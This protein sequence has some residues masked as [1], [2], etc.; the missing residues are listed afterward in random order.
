MRTFTLQQS[1]TEV[2]TPHGGLALVG[3]CLNRHTSL[4]QT[5]RTVVKRHGIPNIDLIR[6]Y[7]GLITLGKSDF[8]AVESARTDPFFKDAMGIKQ[9]PSSAQLRQRFDEDAQALT[10]LLED[11]S[12][13]FLKSVEAPV[14]PLKMGHVALDMDVFPMD[15]SQTSKE[16]VS[17]TYKGHDGYA[18]IAAYLGQEGWC[19][20]C[21]LRPGNQHANNGFL[22]TLK[23]VLPR[24]RSLTGSPILLRLDSAHDA[25][26]NRDFLSQQEQVD[27]LIKW[28]PRKQDPL[29]WADKAQEQ[30]GWALGRY[31]KMEAVLSE[32]LPDEPGIR[33]I[34]KVTVRTSDAQGQLYL[35]PDVR[36]EGW[37]TSL[38]VSVA[39]NQQVIDLYC[40]HATSEQFHSEFKTDLD[41]ERLPSGKF[42][43][44]NLVMTFATLGYNV[45]RWMGLRLTGP[46]APVRH[47]AKRRRLRTVMQELMYM[48]CR[49][50]HSSRQR[51]LRFG[52]HCPG[53]AVYRDLYRGLAS[54]G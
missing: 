10:P 19:L 32:E 31:G 14:S 54:P 29:V 6:T 41:L 49:L 50:I 21:E 28:N 8:E 4:P 51:F 17:Y 18:P 7:L 33:R 3:H 9:S 25:R 52:R 16:G 38:P 12:C 37:V 23:R 36:L 46:D 22:E 5:A 15:N 26:D 53:F 30:Q 1:K 34:V 24:A 47:P 42:A 11:A 45:L 43:T 39:S 35:E 48:A 44:N 20:G 2:Y 13:E 27:F 40:D